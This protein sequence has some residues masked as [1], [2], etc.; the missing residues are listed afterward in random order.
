VLLRQA[1]DYTL[2]VNAKVL[3][4]TVNGASS[5][6]AVKLMEIDNNSATHYLANADVMMVIGNINSQGAARPVA[7]AQTP[8]E[9]SNYTQI[10]R[11]SLDLSRTLMQT[12]LRTVDAYTEAKRDTLE[13]HSLGM[14]KALLWGIQSI[15]VGANGLPESTT[16]GLIPM[17]KAYGTV[18]DFSLDSASAYSGKTWLEGGC[19]WLD[20]HIE[21]IFR[22]GNATERLVFCGTGA[23]LGIQKLVK[24][25]GFYNLT[26]ETSAFGIQVIRWVTPFGRLLFKTHP[27][28]S[29]EETNRYSMVIFTPADITYRF[30]Q[31]TIFKADKSDTEGGGT[32]KDGKEEEFLTE[33]GLE[34]HFPST[35]GYLNGVG[36]DNTV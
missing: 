1:A 11:D 20:E 12:K 30:L 4:V 23:L 21:E 29:Y 34:Y 16:D 35:W 15:G 25:F 7:I 32:G 2:D 26:P 14:E 31:D 36:L 28:F 10:F 17:I 27:L 19:D 22:Y 9:F 5:Y 18:Q 3:S 13:Q 8:T 33:A 6:V 24:E